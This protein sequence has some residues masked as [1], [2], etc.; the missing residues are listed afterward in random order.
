MAA[1]RIAHVLLQHVSEQTDD[2][3]KQIEAKASNREKTKPKKT[4]SNILT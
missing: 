4:M 2:G 3:E 1:E